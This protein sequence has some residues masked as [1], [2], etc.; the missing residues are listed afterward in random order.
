M[1]AST[2]S[3][4][5]GPIAT[6]W[7][8]AAPSTD[9]PLSTAACRYALDPADANVWATLQEPLSCFIY[10]LKVSTALSRGDGH[11][12]PLVASE[13]HRVPPQD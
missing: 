12:L 10:L 7:Y 3:A 2:Q 8:Q 6:E 5:I 4:L 9:R 11:W 13:R 1:S